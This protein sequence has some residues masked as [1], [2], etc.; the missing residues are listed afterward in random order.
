MPQILLAISEPVHTK[1]SERIPGPCPG[2]LSEPLDCQALSKTEPTSYVYAYIKHRLRI[3]A[4]ICLP[5]ACATR[6]ASKMRH[7]EMQQPTYHV[8]STPGV[9]SMTVPTHLLLRLLAHACGSGPSPMSK[10]RCAG[11]CTCGM[12][13]PCYGTYNAKASSSCCT[14]SHIRLALGL[15][16]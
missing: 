8:R 13:H 9:L 7:H 14:S 5:V 15:R 12:Q 2:I 10:G 3:P 11:A 16:L 6:L 1:C 4:S